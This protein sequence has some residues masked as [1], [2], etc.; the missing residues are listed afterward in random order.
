MGAM[1]NVFIEVEDALAF[2]G[3]VSHAD[4]SAVN[5]ALDFAADEYGDYRKVTAFGE[6]VYANRL[7][8]RLHLDDLVQTRHAMRQDAAGGLALTTAPLSVEL[9][10]TCGT[11]DENT[12]CDCLDDSLNALEDLLE[13]WAMNSKAYDD[14]EVVFDGNVGW[15]RSRAVFSL[16]SISAGKFYRALANTECRLVFSLDALATTLS[17]VRYS[18]DEPVG[19]SFKVVIVDSLAN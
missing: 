9:V 13:T 19:A 11:C 7:I 6:E 17:V 2:L 5:D 15:D 10:T 8:T 16:D 3:E 4:V 12:F 18:H 14:S 1:K